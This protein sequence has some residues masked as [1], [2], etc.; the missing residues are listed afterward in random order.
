MPL[1]ENPFLESLL[2]EKGVAI[3]PNIHSAYVL[4]H[5]EEIKTGDVRPEGTVIGFSYPKTSTTHIPQCL[6]LVYDESKEGQLD[7]LTVLECGKLTPGF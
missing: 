2:R 3:V 5:F 7:A 4:P 1:Q 6:A